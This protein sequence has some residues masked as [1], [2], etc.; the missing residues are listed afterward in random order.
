MSR[1]ER[2]VFVIEQV[3]GREVFSKLLTDGSPPVHERFYPTRQLAIPDELQ[4]LNLDQ[5]IALY[6][7]GFIK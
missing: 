5:T 3:R 2:Y 4:G 7:L 1:A 6:K